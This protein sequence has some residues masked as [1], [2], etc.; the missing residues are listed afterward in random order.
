[1]INYTLL[2]PLS[3]IKPSFFAFLVVANKP[4]FKFVHTVQGV[5]DN[6][7]IKTCEILGPPIS[8]SKKAF[9]E[10]YLIFRPRVVVRSLQIGW[11]FSP[12]MFSSWILN[13]DDRS[14][15]F[16]PL[17]GCQPNKLKGFSD[18]INFKLMP[19]SES[20]APIF[21]STFKNLPHEHLFWLDLSPI[22][23]YPCQ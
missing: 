1:M 9:T 6:C 2:K 23:V 20:S 16:W 3:N 4:A 11:N 7:L 15:S 12:E 22:I 5:F 8:F 13:S 10:I 19:W 21:I 17:L 18:E 14:T